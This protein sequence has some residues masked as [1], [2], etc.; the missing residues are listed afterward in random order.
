MIALLS[1]ALVAAPAAP[2][3]ASQVAPLP[4]TADLALGRD[5]AAK[6]VPDGIYQ[7]LMDGMMSKMMGGMTDQMTA[8]PLAPFLRAAGMAPAD[9]AKLGQA[10]IKQI[11]DIVDPAYQQRMQ[12]M[13]PTMMQEMGKVMTQ[14]EPQMREGLAE[15][16]AVHFTSAQLA[17]IDHFFNT[18]SGNAFAAQN[19]TIATDPA[20]MQKMQAFMPKL[21]E[22]MPAI[23]QKVM[24]ATAGL[25]KPKTAK[26]LSAA[27]R[28]K[29]AKLLGID[30]EKLNQAAK[31]PTS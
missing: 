26:D 2:V 24:A 30:T 17:D 20:V 16:Y 19:M 27:D 12:I 14:F 31:E 18:P 23:M 3:A 22:A 15:A 13:M 25:P 5:I 4:S 10:T 21:F 1:L 29:L 6:L 7:K 11:M 28:E 8:M 9:T